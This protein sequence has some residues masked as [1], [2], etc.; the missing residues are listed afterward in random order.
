[1]KRI[2]WNVFLTLFLVLVSIFGL[3]PSLF[4]DGTNTE[5]M[6]TLIIVA[7]L[8]LLLIAGFYFV[9]RKKPK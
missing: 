7:I 6:Y 8:Y 9:N 2:I 5:R 3:G 1:M 4:A